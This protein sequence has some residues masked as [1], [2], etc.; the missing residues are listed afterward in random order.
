MT[1]C[2]RGE[3]L[4]AQPRT[5]ADG[6]QQRFQSGLKETLDALV[7]RLSKRKS[8]TQNP[9]EREKGTGEDLLMMC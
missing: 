7:E 5:E 9:A 8:G 2:S 6:E 4:R 1:T 3:E